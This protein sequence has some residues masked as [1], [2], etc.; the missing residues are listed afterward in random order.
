MKTLSPLFSF[1]HDGEKFYSAVKKRLSKMPERTLSELC[2]A[3]DLD[4]STAWRWHRG[5]KPDPETVNAVERALQRFERLDGVVDLR[6][7]A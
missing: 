5:S 2:V 3:A 7:K 4:F 1:A 6:S